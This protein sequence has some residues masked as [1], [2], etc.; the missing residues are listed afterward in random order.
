[1]VAGEIYSWMI[2]TVSADASRCATTAGYFEV[3]FSRLKENAMELEFRETVHM[4]VVC[5]EG[6]RGFLS[7]RGGGDLLDR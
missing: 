7:R 4:D 5:R 2:A 1:M 3:G 6:Q